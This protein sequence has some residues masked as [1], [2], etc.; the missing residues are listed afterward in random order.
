[1]SSV[2]YGLSTSLWSLVQQEFGGK[3]GHTCDSNARRILKEISPAFNTL[4]FSAHCRCGS[5]CSRPFPTSP[6][7]L[8]SLCFST[9]HFGGP[10]FHLLESF[11]QHCTLIVLDI[12]PCKYWWP[13]PTS[14]AIHSYLLARKG[15]LSALLVPSMKELYIVVLLLIYQPFL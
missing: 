13:R 14:R 12:Y 8:S 6:H 9:E 1:M 5:V 15:D 3:S 4:S 10:V 11:H 7:P 2:Q